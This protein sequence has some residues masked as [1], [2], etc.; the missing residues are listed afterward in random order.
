MKKRTNN[1]RFK[2]NICGQW[3]M[4]EFYDRHYMSKRCLSKSKNALLV[5]GSMTALIP[6]VNWIPT[7]VDVSS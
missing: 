1:D 4:K 3:V 6:D 5:L 2:C 7:K